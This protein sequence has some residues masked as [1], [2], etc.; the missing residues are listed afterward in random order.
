MRQSRLV[1]LIVACALFMENTDSTVIATSLPAI[2]ADLNQDPISLKL[3]ITSYLVSLAV[4]I[5]ISGWMADRYGARTIFRLAIAVFMAGSLACAAAHSLG[6]FVLARFLQGMGGAMMVPVGRLVL[7]RTVPRSELVSAL[8][9][10]TVP[11]LIGPV[12]GPPLGGFITTY[13]DWRWIFFINIP[14]GILGMV[15]ATIFIENVKEPDPPPLDIPGYLMLATGLASLMLGLATA[16]RHLLPIEASVACG[17]GGVL[18]LGAYFW[19]SRRVIHPVVKLSLLRIETFRA[20]VLGGAVFR[21][22]VGA[23]P[24]LLP[25]MLQ[26]GFGLDPIQSGLLT[27][28]SAAG[29]LFMK[30]LAAR[31]LRGVGFRTVLATNAIVASMMMGIIGIFTPSTPY[32]VIITLLL[33]GGCFRSLQFTA[34]N[35]ISYADVPSRDMSYA[36]SL[37]SVAQQISLSIGV[38]IGAFFLETSSYLHGHA[39]LQAS[40]FWPAFALVAVVA[41]TSAAFFVRLPSDAG[42]ELSGHGVVAKADR[43]A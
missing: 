25:L 18:L 19:R 36:T 28:A 17:A 37:T 15:L 10:L 20:G 31:I 4:F 21:I 11:A 7:L 35:A 9:Y 8:A 26:I 34:L 39:T 27:F 43:P 41:A 5:P 16:G 32:V 13:F 22:G 23:I 24:F 40:D 30:T 1:P 14:I 6:S 12:I 3:A 2:A 33:V 38:T 29:A 42:A